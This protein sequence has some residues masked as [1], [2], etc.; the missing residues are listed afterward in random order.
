[1]TGPIRLVAIDADGTLLDPDGAI[2][3]RVERAVRTAIAAGCQVVLATG[4]RLQSA[5]PIARQVGISTLILVNG[6][7]VYDLSS[8]ETLY[9]HAL[10]PA[11]CRRVVELIQSAG[12]PPVLLESPVAGARIV[13]GPPELD[14]PDT[15]AYLGRKDEVVRVLAERLPDL[16]HIVIALGMGDRARVA[17]LE[18]LAREEPL[19][20][21]IDWTS[22]VASSQKYGYLTYVVELVARGVSKG[23]A[24]R[25]LASGRGIPIE[26]TLAIGDYENDVSMVEAAGVGIAMGN[27]VP[28]VRAAARAIV[29]DNEHDGVAEAIEE[30]VLRND[31]ETVV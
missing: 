30:W 5:G 11:L 15:A 26:Q 12:L 13:A 25:W 22:A 24:L 6:A 14:N 4:R 16:E 8:R 9:E 1:V 27:A 31:L 19:L 2:R 10:S 3:P 7:V 18:D 17:R 28:S 21:S 20:D 23:A 29:A